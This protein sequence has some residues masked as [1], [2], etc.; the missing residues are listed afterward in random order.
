MKSSV[1]S[2]ARIR[3]VVTL[4][5]F[6]VLGSL[7]CNRAVIVPAETS[8]YEYTVPHP[9]E[10]VFDAALSVAQR[11]NLNV[12]VLEKQSGLLRF[13]SAYLTPLQLDQ[14]CVYPFTGSRTRQPLDTFAEWNKRA[15]GM[16][17]GTVS[18]TALL[19]DRP[20]GQT[21]VNVRGNWT[22]V[23]PGEAF[24]LNSKKI[25]EAQFQQ[26]LVRELASHGGTP[27][28]SGSIDER[29][30][31]LRQ[32]LDAGLIERKDY[33]RKRAEVLKEL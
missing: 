30:E 3:W 2:D 15:N 29:L 26:D 32:L 1:A 8:L 11:L 18:L 5:C 17:R 13:E 33:E 27:Q 20:G 19:S 21:A 24:N 31:A 28:A 14:Y 9:R 6:L 16:V 7:S 22:A 4:G 23:G 10:R 12:A 25:L